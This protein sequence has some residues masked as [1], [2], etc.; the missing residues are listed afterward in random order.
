MVSV[1]PYYSEKFLLSK[2]AMSGVL[3]FL[4]SMFD[5]KDTI[6]M[7]HH[8]FVYFLALAIYPKSLF[9]VIYSVLL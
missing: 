6:L 9:V 8:Y 5:I 2:V 4:T 3:V 1:Q 7:K